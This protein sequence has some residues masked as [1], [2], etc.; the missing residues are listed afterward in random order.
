MDHDMK[1]IRRQAGVQLVEVIVAM[2]IASIIALAIS[3]AY[4]ASTQIQ[5]SQI[6]TMRLNETA[7]FA[8][9][10]L[11]K[12]LRHAGF[13]NTWQGGSNAQR[14]CTATI[15][16]A[17]NGL[18]DVNG[19]IDPT[20]NN[21]LG[22]AYTIANRSDVIRVSYYGEDGSAVT[23]PMLDCHGYPIPSGVSIQETLFVAVDNATQEPSLYCDTSNAHA[24]GAPRALPLVTG[25]ES[26]QLLYGLDANA[27]GLIDQYVP[28]NLVGA[29]AD[30]VT[31]VKVSLVVRSPTDSA[32]DTVNTA[33]ARTLNHFGEATYPAA[34]KAANSDAGATF[35][36]PVD[37]RAR[38]L[39]TTELGMRNFS[40]CG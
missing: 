4:I 24:N 27:D 26:M 7:R 10:L 36:T 29:N 9:D 1:H 40:Y 30:L 25:V 12:E 3:R 20:T 18:N 37:R 15:G 13:S 21:L 2:A 33:V 22:G 39:S 8:F 17:L 34:A 16:S 28:W 23:S 14:Y 38:A 6:G 19:T 11:G 32:A 31:S 35:I 5:T